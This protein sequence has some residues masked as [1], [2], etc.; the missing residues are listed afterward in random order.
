MAQG[1]ELLP[2]RLF[3]HRGFTRVLPENSMAA[4]DA[5]AALGIAGAEIDLRTTSDGHVVL[6]HDAAVDRTTT[7]TGAVNTLTWDAL[8]ALRLERPDGTATGEP[9]PDLDAVLAFLA[10][11]PGFAVAFDAKAI[12]VA[13]VGRRVSAAGLQDAVWFFIDDPLD[14]AR[15]QAVKRADPRLRLSVN[16]MSWW[17]VEGLPTFVAQSLA[18]DALFSHEFYFPRFGGTFAEAKRAGAQVQVYI[19]GADNLPARLREAVRIGADVVSTDRPDLLAGLVVPATSARSS[20][21][22]R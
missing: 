1:P 18:A 6:M 4:L 14:V 20:G 5:A 15:A 22:S 7:G 16:L 17:K 3:A 21:S 2:V 8:R 9:V 19:P 10:K 13:A 12:D 11:R